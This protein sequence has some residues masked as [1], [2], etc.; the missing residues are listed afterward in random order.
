ML[1]TIV[2]L[3]FRKKTKYLKPFLP[4]LIVVKH[5]I[6]AIILDSARI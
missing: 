1:K 3:R 5:L 6:I 2:G 4:Y